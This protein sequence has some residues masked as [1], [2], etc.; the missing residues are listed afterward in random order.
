VQSSITKNVEED[1]LTELLT[2]EA[3]RD[4]AA[5][6]GRG[7]FRAAGENA[8]RAGRI[9]AFT[10]LLQGAAGYAGARSDADRWIRLADRENQWRQ[11]A[12]GGGAQASAGFD[13][14]G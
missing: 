13:Y 7:R 6:R 2:G 1:A 9:G 12:Q 14:P 8:E 5:H 10:S 11:R 4:G 3:A